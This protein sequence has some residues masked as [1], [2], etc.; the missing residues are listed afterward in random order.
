MA[1]E[2]EVYID[3]R[4]LKIPELKKELQFRGLKTSG[5]KQELIDRLEQYM[6][7]HE[8][9]EVADDDLLKEEGEVDDHLADDKK[10]EDVLTSDKEIEKKSVED[11]NAVQE[12]ES[13]DKAS[14]VTDLHT[15]G[16]LTD[17]EKLAVRAKKFGMTI[18][19]MNSEARKV[20]RSQRF[21]TGTIGSAEAPNA[22]ILKKRAER[23]G[24]VTSG[25]VMQSKEEERRRKRQARFGDSSATT[26][27]G[28]VDKKKR[29]AERFGLTV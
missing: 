3:L 26:G 18:T 15:S 2:E 28:D 21:G 7:E 19:D 5:N 1:S 11:D 9:A 13:P 6:E 8:G 20:A 25:T 16:E 24:V 17:Q 14:A 22:E 12:E 27:L 10:I 4:K 23:F 29:R